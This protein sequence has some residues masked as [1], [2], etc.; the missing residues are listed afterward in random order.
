MSGNPLS[1]D[2]KYKYPWQ[3]AVLEI[4][5]EYQGEHI[6]EKLIAAERAVTKRLLERIEDPE[7]RL[8]LQDGLSALRLVFPQSK[9]KLGPVARTRLPGLTLPGILIVDDQLS[10]RRAIRSL[11]QRHDIEV[12]GEAENGKQAIEKVTELEPEL[13]L[14]D[15]SMPVMNGVEAAYKIR[16]IVPSTKILFLSVY[17][18]ASFEAV[19]GFVSDGFVSK[20]A[21][22]TELIPAVK[23]ILGIET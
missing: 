3:K 14:L 19:S 21:A 22:A 8:A 13:V 5:L 1:P 7:E 9:L 11:L 10:A 2:L 23:R 12:C 15:I 6:S 16:R 18:S 20:I 4:L 17:D